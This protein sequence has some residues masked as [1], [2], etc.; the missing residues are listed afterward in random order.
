MG[1]GTIEFKSQLAGAV[2]SLFASP[3]PPPP[4]PPPFFEDRATMLS[5]TLGWMLPAL[6]FISICTSEKKPT[7]TAAKVTA[8]V[9]VDAKG[10]AVPKDNERRQKANREDASGQAW[11]SRKQQMLLAAFFLVPHLL[12]W[13]L[14]ASR[15]QPHGLQA[16][17][18]AHLEPHLV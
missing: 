2:R 1:L 18:E 6:L 12:A 17:F 13:Q 8:K 7:S 14:Q 16:R 15:S 5:V 9:A 11:E 3:P 10:A 4:P